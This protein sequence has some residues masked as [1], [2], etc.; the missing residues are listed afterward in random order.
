MKNLSSR[1]VSKVPGTEHAQHGMWL[2]Q[3]AIMTHRPCMQHLG[4]IGS[5]AARQI[6]FY[7]FNLG[8]QQHPVLTQVRLSTGH[9]GCQMKPING[10]NGIFFHTFLDH[11]IYV[12]NILIIN[13][14]QP[15]PILDWPI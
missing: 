9:R 6:I 15:K 10:I 1:E 12:I 14:H 8:H 11:S 13:H 7:N 3:W 4:N 5:R 2:L